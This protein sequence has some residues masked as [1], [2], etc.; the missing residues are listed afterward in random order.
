MLLNQ[1]IINFSGLDSFTFNH[2]F[3]KCFIETS[4]RTSTS[5]IVDNSHIKNTILRKPKKG[6]KIIAIIG[7]SGV[8][9]ATNLRKI[10]CDLVNKDLIK[11]YALWVDS[12][13]LKKNRDVINTFK[14]LQKKAYRNKCRKKGITLFI[15]GLDRIYSLK[16][17]QKIITTLNSLKKSCDK[18]V[19]SSRTV[20]YITLINSLQDVISYTVLPWSPSEAKSFLQKYF[21]SE[22][23]FN[24][25]IKIFGYKNMDI[26]FCRPFS[27][28]LFAYIFSNE[29]M[30]IGDITTNKLISNLYYLYE[31]FYNYWIA[32][33]FL[34][35]PYNNI[36]ANEV[37]KIHIEVACYLYEN[38]DSITQL[39][40]IVS[41]K[42]IKNNADIDRAVLSLLKF[43]N[44]NNIKNLKIRG[45]ID[46]SL[47]EFFITK[48]I[49]LSIHKERNLI[50]C[51]KMEYFDFKYSFIEDSFRTLLKK[52]INEL[53]Q[54][55][56]KIFNNLKS[57]EYNKKYRINYEDKKIIDRNIR[58]LSSKLSL[59]KN[60]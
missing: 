52:E 24:D 49:I 57:E 3:N 46:E 50:N 7:D 37:L 44:G 29:Y 39:K 41:P 60:L 5:N 14:G 56:N 42:Y 32:K 59:S 8:G 35:N 16:D 27:T 28:L 4:Y 23:I 21:R 40:D 15:E 11:G 10:Y 53:D 19:V 18:I 9:K 55:L 43:T 38:V 54:N 51:L 25:F 34:Y 1:K 30:N 20:N 2:L 31:F 26:V 13:T 48:K 45:F 12:S 6:P 17:S 36:S 58:Y 22:K 47:I 33:E